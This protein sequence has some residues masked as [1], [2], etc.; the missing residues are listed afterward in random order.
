MPLGTLRGLCQHVVNPERD[1]GQLIEPAAELDDLATLIQAR[2]G[3]RRHA[4]LAKFGQARHS[5][6]PEQRNRAIALGFSSRSHT[7]K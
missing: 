4:R 3:G 5:A 2:Y 1:V 6:V 7:P